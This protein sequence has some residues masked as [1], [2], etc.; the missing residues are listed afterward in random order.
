MA[1]LFSCE[2][3][4]SK[5]RVCAFVVG[6]LLLVGC[7][8]A[9]KEVAQPAVVSVTHPVLADV[10]IWR[11][12]IGTLTGMVNASILPQISGYVQSQNY[13]NGAFV[14]KGDV[15]FRIDQTLFLDEVDGAAA[16]LAE[17]K[18]QWQQAEY[19]KNLYKP[20]S[21]DNVV[22]KQQYENAVLSAQASQ[23]NILAAQ[24]N[25]SLAQRNLNYTVVTSPI[26][27][28]AGIASVQVGD[29]VS[30]SGKVLSEV[31][32]VN[33]IRIDFAVTQKQWLEQEGTKNGIRQGAQ[34]DLIFSNGSIYPH[35]AKVI[36]ID[37]AF[38]LSTGTIMIQAQVDNAELL[39]RPG[40][41]V[42]VRAL[43][44]MDKNVLTVP[45]KA[46]Y[47]TQ[48]RF[49]VVIINENN[50]PE[51]VPVEAGAME[52]GSQVIRAIIPNSVTVDSR[53]VVDGIQQAMMDSARGDAT[54]TTIPYHS[55]KAESAKSSESSE[56]SGK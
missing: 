27:G 28:I 35:P 21:A 56:S 34:V 4:S 1:S 50:K 19:N 38:D 49:F 54:L 51:M 20:L 11:E 26:D 55:E 16:K 41:F 5:A 47:S 6:A 46:I 25:L 30:P 33:P 10:P 18:A 53:V 13:D 2:I 45:Q 42:R 24:A 31:S 48:G 32:S 44:S 36:A 39:L 15:L 23:A 43:M 3:F 14:K 7:K 9:S 12:W 52:K 40:M 17:A 22:S 37:R 8:P 29:L